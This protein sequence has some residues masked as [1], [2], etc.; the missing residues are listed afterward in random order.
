MGNTEH[1]HRDDQDIAGRL[2]FLQLDEAGCKNLRRL[3]DTIDREMP[4]ALERFYDTVARTPQTAGF[5]SSQAQMTGA[6]N[7]QI[8]HWQAITDG[9]FDQNYVERVRRIGT[10]HARIGLEPRWYIGGYAL[11]TEQLIYGVIREH[12]PK[13]GL[14]PRKAIAPEE[15]GAL[16]SSLVKAILLDMDLS[17]SIYV[18]EAEEMKR[19]AQ[20]KATAEQRLVVDT[21]GEAIRK[22]SA[23]DLTH[24]IGDELPD[25]YS[26]L[27]DAFNTALQQLSETID[28]IGDSAQQISSGANEIQSAAD[29]LS[30]RAEQQAA[31]VEETSAAVEEI[32]VAVKSSTVRAEENGQLVEKVRKDAEYSGEVVRRAVDA[33]ERIKN[34]SDDISRIIGVIDEIAF[35]TNL[36]ALNAGVEAARAGDAGKGFAVVAQEVRELAQRSATAA[37]EIKE[38]ITTS[39]EEVQ[40]GVS[41]VSESGEVLEKIDTS[42]REVSTNMASIIEAAREQSGGLQEING[43]ITSVDRGTQQNAAMAEE[44]NASCHSLNKEVDSINTLLSRFKTSRRIG[45]ILAA[46]QQ[47][48]TAAGTDTTA[49][50]A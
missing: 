39:G 34:S 14:L 10:T 43:A 26:G 47:S 38:L 42:V 23:K 6:K 21:F 9:I 12:W 20:E 31:S 36:L 25:S 41:Q 45:A 48:E 24:R 13:R 40:S 19:A 50:I 7:A 17:I 28:S 44:L 8:R 35:Q 33:M 29:N 46:N 4:P 11:V 2:S 5:F 32:T 22:I 37:K 1:Q 15:V 16:L 49:R 18:D 27:V 30:Q 3:K